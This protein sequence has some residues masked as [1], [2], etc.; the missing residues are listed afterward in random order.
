MI[1]GAGLH[2]PVDRLLPA[3][4]GPDPARG[5]ARGRDRRLRRVRPQRRLVLGA[6]PGLARRR[7][8][9]LPGS[10]TVTPPLAQHQAM[11]ATVDEVLAV[12]G[13]RGHRRPGAQGRHGRAGPHRGPAAPRARAEVGLGP[14]VGPRRGRPP[15]ARRRRGPGAAATPPH[16]LGGDLHPGL[17]G[18]PSRAAGA[19]AGPRGR[20]ARRA[21]PRGHPGPRARAAAGGH[22]ARRGPRRRRGPGHRG[23]H[24]RRWTACAATWCRST[25]SSSRP[26]RC[27]TPCGSGSGCADRET[28]TDHRNLIVYGQRTADGR[29]VFGGRG[30]P[31]HFGSAVQPGY[32]RERAGLRDAARDAGRRCSRCSPAAAVHAR[33]GRRAGHPPGL[34]A[35]RSASTAPPAS[36]G[37]A[38]TSATAS[39]RRTWPAARCATWSSA[40]TPS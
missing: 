17:R 39:V 4:R 18:G 3:A 36:A 22:R 27:R 8:A 24:R 7:L 31:Y 5:R 21:D 30:A 37:P 2:R 34:G 40:A 25:P 26:S 19:R 20:A 12:A 1:V 29:L 16:V 14:R 9:A 15:A 23:L 38:A 33:L 11:R 13:R 28:F 35:P 10:S 32:D 6:V